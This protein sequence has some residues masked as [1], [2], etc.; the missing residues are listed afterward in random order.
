MNDHE[1]SHDAPVSMVG[2]PTVRM[3]SYFSSDYLWA[4]IHF[5]EQAKTIEQQNSGPARKDPTHRAYVIGAIVE[6]CAG[7]E[8]AINEVFVDVSD[9]EESYVGPLSDDAKRLLKWQWGSGKADQLPVLDK[10][11]AVL[12]AAAQEPFDSGAQPYQDAALLIELRNYL[13]HYK[14]H[15][16][17]EDLPHRLE[18]RLKSARFAA[19]ALMTGSGNAF[20]PDHALGAGCAIW[21]TSTARKFLD[22]FCRQSGLNLNYQ[23]VI[24]AA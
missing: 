19:N 2:S 23:R 21:A 10:F 4:A 17:A 6:S 1:V 11:N 7:I 15:W 5:A 13:M 8:A 22:E 20:F 14:P 3:R 16:V 24:D 18:G 9:E 12:V